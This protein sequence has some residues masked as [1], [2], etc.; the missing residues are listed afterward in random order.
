MGNVW[1]DFLMQLGVKPEKPFNPMVFSDPVAQ[2]TAWTPLERGG[3]NFGSHGLVERDSLCFEFKTTLGMKV[4]YSFFLLFGPVVSFLPLLLLFLKT[5]H[6]RLQFTPNILFGLL[7]VVI[8]SFVIYKAEQPVVFDKRRGVYRKGWPG[9]ERTIALGRIRGLQ[10]L[11]EFCHGSKNSHYYSYE[12]NLVLD[13]ASRANVVDH[14]NLKRSRKDAE[15][16]SRFL[17]VQV[18]DMQEAGR[19]A[20]SAP[21]GD[22]WS[23]LKER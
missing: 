10:I 22:N 5:G 23:L 18:W 20:A 11:S 2:A 15:A 21:Q 13:D 14:G 9:R 19:Q 8:G 7:F 17:G 16:L 1:Q 12:L 4:M 3:T 6:L